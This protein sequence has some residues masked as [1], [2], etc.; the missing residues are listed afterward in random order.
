MKTMRDAALGCNLA[1]GLVDAVMDRVRTITDR[2]RRLA[3]AVR[4]DS[5]EWTGGLSMPMPGVALATAAA[6][7]E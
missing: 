3:S 1:W 7:G 6:R 4:A 2:G 5:R